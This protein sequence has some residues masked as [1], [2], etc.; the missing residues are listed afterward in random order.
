V[1]APKAFKKINLTGLKAWQENEAQRMK[2][3]SPLDPDPS[4]RQLLRAWKV[5][6]ELPPRFGERVWRRIDQEAARSGESFW[7]DLRQRLRQALAT[8]RLAASYLV[9]LLA[10]GLLAGQWQAR[11]ASSRYTDELGSRYVQMM[12]PYQSA[13]H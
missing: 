7:Q 1:A 2:S 9:V 5:R 8:P 11:A 10:A 4:L 12:D 3:E 13:H 6:D